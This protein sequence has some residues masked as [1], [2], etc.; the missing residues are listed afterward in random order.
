MVV[1]CFLGFFLQV[2]HSIKAIKCSAWAYI[3]A[4]EVSFLERASLSINCSEQNIAAEWELHKDR[5][6][7]GKAGINDLNTFFFSMFCRSPSLSM[8]V[9]ELHNLPDKGGWAVS[10]CCAMALIGWKGLGRRGK[11]CP[12]LH[13]EVLEQPPKLLGGRTAMELRVWAD[14][15]GLSWVQPICGV[16][17]THMFSPAAR[18]VRMLLMKVK[19]TF[20]VPFILP[21]SFLEKSLSRL[22]NKFWV[23]FS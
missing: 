19:N 15:Q 9:W 18:R 21:I 2:L 6:C 22:F 12:N 5:K 11:L 23:F 8:A 14:I 20:S 1:F 16:G 10:F 13:L 3:T 4:V 7:P 17:R